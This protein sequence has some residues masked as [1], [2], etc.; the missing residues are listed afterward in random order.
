LTQVT[1]AFD[2]AAVTACL[3]VAKVLK[4][5]YQVERYFAVLFSFFC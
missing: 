3:D 1:L 2:P 5:L 4:G